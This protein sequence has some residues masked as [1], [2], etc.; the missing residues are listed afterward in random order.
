MLWDSGDTLYKAYIGARRNFWYD[1]NNTWIRDTTKC[2]GQESANCE[3]CSQEQPC[4]FD[5]SNVQSEYVDLA[6]TKPSILSVM[7][8]QFKRYPKPY[9]GKF[10]VDLSKYD[11]RPSVGKN[12]ANWAGKPGTG[13]FSGP[14]CTPTVDTTSSVS[15]SY[16]WKRTHWVRD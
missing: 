13:N 2:I 7:L 5:V 1:A 14:C 12:G 10:Q 9:V 6:K 4:L 8:A 15:V 3:V 11:C 16:D